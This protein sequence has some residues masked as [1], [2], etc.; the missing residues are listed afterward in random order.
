MW[1]IV[2]LSH[3]DWRLQNWRKNYFH[4]LRRPYP[5]PV[6]GWNRPKRWTSS[7]K[8]A[9]LLLEI[10]PYSIQFHFT[11]LLLKH[12]HSSGFSACFCSVRQEKKKV[13][14]SVVLAL[15]KIF[16]L[17]LVK[18]GVIKVKKAHF[19]GHWKCF[20]TLHIVRNLHFFSKNSTLISR[21]NCRFFLVK[22][23]WKWFGF[24]LFSCWQ[25]WF[26]EKNCQKDLEWKTR[27]NVE[28][29]L[30]KVKF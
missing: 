14:V 3:L 26:H 7:W 18:T 21:E 8:R 1:N 29:V 12:F 9:R 6:R 17:G 30:S 23:S 27:K 10:D 22:N 15:I 19:M 13:K 11:F 24:G 4:L 16:F 2:G 28:V 25:L 20:W 5:L